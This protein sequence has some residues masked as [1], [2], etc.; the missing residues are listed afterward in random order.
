M[1]LVEV[2]AGADR[3]RAATRLCRAWDEALVARQFRIVVV[4]GQ[5]G[6]GRTNMLRALYQHCAQNQS[7]W[8]EQI[9]A[10]T[11]DATIDLATVDS[12]VPRQFGPGR[13]LSALY[14]LRPPELP[15]PAGAEQI[16][17]EWTA[18]RRQPPIMRYFWWGLQARSGGFAV[19]DGELQLRSHIDT[20][21]EAVLR[22]DTHRQQGSDGGH[23]PGSEEPH[24]D[25]PPQPPRPLGRSLPARSCP[26]S[27]GRR[28]APRR[29]RSLRPHL[30]AGTANCR[31]ASV[32]RSPTGPPECTP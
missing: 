14:D 5:S 3:L 11:G 29:P 24:S 31:H 28:P 21:K 27:P 22:A 4:R 18:R 26:A 32:R 8:A 1:A 19:L 30:M 2:W 17:A 6:S 9:R 12:I 7:C 13:A 16:E 15:S 23:P 20:L 10:A 25:H